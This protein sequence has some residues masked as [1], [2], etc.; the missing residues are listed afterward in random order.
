MPQNFSPTERGLMREL[1]PLYCKVGGEAAWMLM[2]EA[3]L[4]G[5]ALERAMDAFIEERSSVL[6]VMLALRDDPS[7]RAEIRVAEGAEGKRREACRALEGT[8]I[9][10]RR[11]DWLSLLPPYAVGCRLRLVPA[12][13]PGSFP[14][15]HTRAARPSCPLLCPLLCAQ[16]CSE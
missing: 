6:D 7:L 12:A 16:R 10:S 3:G 5:E 13:E 14:P 2:E 9:S 8:E 11:E 4:E 15:E 1:H